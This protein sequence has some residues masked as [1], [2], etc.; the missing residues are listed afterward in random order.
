LYEQVMAYGVADE[1]KGF[2]ATRDELIEYESLSL[3]S[4]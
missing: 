4:P 3:G 1:V 2:T